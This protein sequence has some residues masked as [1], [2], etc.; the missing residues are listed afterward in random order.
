MCCCLLILFSSFSSPS[1]ISPSL[2]LF[3]P[4]PSLHP[5]ITTIHP[6]SLKSSQH[7]THI[8]ISILLYSSPTLSSLFTL[9]LSLSSTLPFLI[10]Y[11]FSFIPIIIFFRSFLS[12]VIAYHSSILWCVSWPIP[13]FLGFDATMPP[14]HPPSF[15][16]MCDSNCTK[17]PKYC[18][19][20]I[21]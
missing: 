17:A 11:T 8:I 3:S 5:I 7:L 18:L 19:V 21:K 13:L 10:S 1:L 4:S 15:R 9:T 6:L 16:S 2:P 12:V 20:N 14:S